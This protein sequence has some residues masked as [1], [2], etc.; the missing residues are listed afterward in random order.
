[1]R[2]PRRPFTKGLGG[3]TQQVAA[4]AAELEAAAGGCGAGPELELAAAEP[5]AAELEAAAGGCRAGAELE[6][7]A[8]EPAA[9]VAADLS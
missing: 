4:V 5:A 2:P 1:M 8:A 9:G 3:R 6:L 7:V